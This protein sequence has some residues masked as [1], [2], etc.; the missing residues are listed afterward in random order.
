MEFKIHA[1]GA[2]EI[3]TRCGKRFLYSYGVAVAY[4]S[5]ERMPYAV[6]A[7][8]NY[9]RADGFVSR[10]TERHIAAFIPPGIRPGRMPASEIQRRAQEAC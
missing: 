4:C 9:W 8:L 6:R 7:T 2:V 1:P 5:V 3:Q 10:T